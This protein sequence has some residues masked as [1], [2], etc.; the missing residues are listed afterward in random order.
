MGEVPDDWR[1]VNVVPLFKKGFREKP[2]NYMP[3]SLTSVVRKLLES[4]WRDTTYMHIDGQ[5][6]IR[7]SQHCF[8]QGRKF[9]TN[10]IEFSMQMCPKR[11][12]RAEL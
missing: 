1:L 5:E 2:G 9:L 12:M 11:L 6:L 10:L 8:V 3:V 4:I 7:D